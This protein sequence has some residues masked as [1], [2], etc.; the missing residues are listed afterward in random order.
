MLG[1]IRSPERSGLSAIEGGTSSRNIRLTSGQQANFG[2]STGLNEPA[3]VLL[4]APPGRE[5]L[6]IGQSHVATSKQTRKPSIAVLP[7]ADRSPGGDQEHF[8]EGVAEDIITELSRRRLLF[9]ISRNSSFLY[10]GRVVDAG[11][12]SRD[13]GVRYLLEGSV[14]RSGK[15]IR[16]NARLVD[17]ESDHT[18]WAQ[19][20]DRELSDVFAVQDEITNSVT[21]ELEPTILQAEKERAVRKAP[22]NL[23]AW[24]AYQ[25]G[26]WHVDRITPADNDAAR[27]L[28]HLAIKL[29]PA[30]SSAYQALSW[31][32]VDDVIVFVTR[33][34]RETLELAEPLA[35]TALSLDPGDA[36][37][38][39][40]VGTLA[41]GHGDLKASLS[42]AE[43]A[44]GL[45]PNCAGAYRL[46]G[47][48]LVFSGR[49]AKGAESLE[50]SLRLNPRDPRNGWT[51]SH[52]GIARYLLKDYQGTVD[53]DRRVQQFGH[54]FLPGHRW[55]V[56]ALGQLGQV[57]EA[58][59]AIEEASAAFA[60]QSFIE[61]AVRPTPWLG[62]ADQAHLLE[63]L[64]KAGCVPD[65]AQ[66]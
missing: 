66:G 60:P 38:H 26:L 25:R 23:G 18:I 50:M 14:R 58:H 35:S 6:E 4:T 24:E 51:V 61:H 56:A 33:T 13:L 16:V 32:Y 65:H 27:K 59:K 5:G 52:V 64:S 21:A 15:R 17:A 63:G 31:T 46:K 3:P 47:M 57:A 34:L 43:T 55:L 2:A 36:G 48:A 49:P 9:V 41:M 12:I 40:A 29:D 62:P 28:F 44:L 53:A 20:Y 42:R 7:F 30:F 11:Q 54:K 39:A 1:T 22:E 37:A 45:N 19:Q 10:R 8:S